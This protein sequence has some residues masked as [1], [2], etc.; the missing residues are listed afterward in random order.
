MRISHSRGESGKTNEMRLNITIKTGKKKKND[1]PGTKPTL[2]RYVLYN[3]MKNDVPR[4]VSQPVWQ[5]NRTI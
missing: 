1:I 5:Y 3:I 4:I 2:F